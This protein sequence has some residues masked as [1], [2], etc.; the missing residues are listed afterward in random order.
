M[1][2]LAAY[3]NLAGNDLT[4]YCSKIELSC[5]VAEQDVTTFGSDGWR[6]VTGGLGSGSLALTFKQDYDPSGLDALMW[7]LFLTRSPQTFE[8]RPSN[9]P[10]SASNPAYSG[11]V[12]L[13]EWS[14]VA[15]T[16]GDVAE[17]DVTFPISG[18]VTRSTS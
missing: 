8:V 12:L 13:T 10:V 15:G 16:V 3:L 18:K 17:A 5:E 11:A 6:E 7:A 9:A 4:Q 14:P 2:L 1:V